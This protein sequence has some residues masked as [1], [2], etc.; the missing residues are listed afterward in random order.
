M[1]DPAL[2]SLFAALRSALKA[3][4]ITYA[5]LARRLG[6]SEPSVKRLFQ[7]Q[8]CKLSR[9]AAICEAIDV[10]LDTLIE[11]SDRRARPSEPLPLEAEHALAGSSDLFHFLLLLLDRF[12]PAQIGATFGLSRASV[13]LYLRDLDRL[14]LIERDVGERFRFLITIPVAWR[15]RGPLGPQL[16]RINQDFVRWVADR[17]GE[18][19]VH[20]LSL[21]RRMRPETA[22]A[23][24]IEADALAERLRQAA[25]RDQL[26]ADDAELRAV[27]L[28]LGLAPLAIQ[29]L[30][31]V[32]EHPEAGV[33][34][35]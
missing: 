19:G 23:L 1:A 29:A 30:R 16:K 25:H 20:F 17:Q 2:Q 24:E 28:T 26:L 31:Y 18:P 11:A 21:T 27:K 8:D 10:P 3:R 22:S 6:V 5:E 15:W 34:R 7:R 14:G 9:L 4:R 12:T 13:D 35:R 32:G 33:R